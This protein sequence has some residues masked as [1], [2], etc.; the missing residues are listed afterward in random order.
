M[1]RAESYEADKSHYERYSNTALYVINMDSAKVHRRFRI[2]GTKT[3]ADFPQ[4]NLDDIT[5]RADFKSREEAVEAL[6]GRT[7]KP[8]HRCFPPPTEEDERINAE[9]AEVR[10]EEDPGSRPEDEVV[11]VSEMDPEDR[12]P[13]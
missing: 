9:F 12:P 6:A 5:H 1:T 13:K 2:E 3:I 7:P 10:E 11:P 4:C 8:C